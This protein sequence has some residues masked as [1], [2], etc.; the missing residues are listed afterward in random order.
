MT[1][2]ALYKL[3]I[4]AALAK[5]RKAEITSVELTQSV[6][7]RIEE[8]EDKI[9]AYINLQPEAA[10]AA[11][12]AADERRAGG[13]DTPLL[14]IP[15]AI[16]DTII[17]QGLTT[18]AGSKILENFVPPFDATVIK[19]L[20]QAGAVLLGKTNH[21]EFAMGSS[22]EYSA[23]GLTRNPWDLE[24]VP[25]GSSGGSAAAIT[26]D[27]AIGTLGSDTGGSVRQPASFC[28]VVG[29][30]PT[31]GRVS[32]YGLIAFGSS[33]DQIGPI[34]K[35]VTDAAVLLGGIAG[36]DNMD[37]TSLNHPVPDY[38]A[39]IKASSGF[40]ELKI[41]IPQEYFIEGMN[42]EVEAAVR[43]AL[44][45]AQAHG[46][47]VVDISLPH[48]RYG[49]PAYYLVAPA[50]ASSNLARYDGVR[51]G[52][53]LPADDLLETYFQTRATGFGPEV[54]RRIMLGTYALSAGYY[55]AYYLKAQKVRTLLRRDFEEAF[56]AVDV[57]FA[58]TTPDVAFKIGQKVDDPL[59][60][61]LSDVFTVVANM[62]GICGIS[63]PC[64]FSQGLPI[65]LQI[66][67]P[68]LGESA[69]LKAAFAYEQAT[70]WHRQKPEL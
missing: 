19:K 35:T 10:L 52:F 50:E 25:G 24:A 15:L 23:Y 51:Y 69:I 68:P 42:P 36:Y 6:L 59:Q 11:A 33:L 3:T 39:E 20:R 12:K 32:R 5:L 43:G 53:R 22:T 31:Y 61:Y 48:T 28:G 40:K 49:I 60:M 18:T 56:Q 8:T 44:Q 46:A 13:D 7:D 9:K 27:E 38:M 67:G 41:G 34:T 37:S 21:D 4:E 29:L 62:A 66:L 30:K 58:P 26:A 47:T 57:I 16:K 55:D 54:K 63:I 70:D 1:D 2:N 45:L 65:G 17:T 14:G 64:G